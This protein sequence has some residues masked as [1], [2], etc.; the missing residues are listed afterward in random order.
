VDGA[1]Y[2]R[3]NTTVGNKDDETVANPCGRKI[4]KRKQA[5]DIKTIGF[6]Y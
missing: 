5:V 4:D 6:K 3:D 1:A 2:W